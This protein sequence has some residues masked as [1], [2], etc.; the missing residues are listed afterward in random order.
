MITNMTTDKIC[1]RIDGIV[2]CLH[3]YKSNLLA[4]RDMV[5]NN[6]PE[7][8]SNPPEEQC[9]STFKLML[10]FDMLIQDY[11]RLKTE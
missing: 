2:E 1:K 6:Y 3:R 5:E 11:H 7:E 10:N 4:G 9:W 8:L